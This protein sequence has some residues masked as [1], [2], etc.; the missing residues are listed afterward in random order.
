MR[1]RPATHAQRGERLD[2]AL[3]AFAKGVYHQRL[4][5]VPAEVLRHLPPSSPSS[6]SAAASSSPS[7]SAAGAAESGGS[8]TACSA[9][10]RVP[11]TGLL[12][13]EDAALT[14]DD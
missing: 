10:E 8:G 5:E 12:S 7:A 2:L 6:S 13:A 9:A 14:P 1:R 4:R 11:I 3:Y